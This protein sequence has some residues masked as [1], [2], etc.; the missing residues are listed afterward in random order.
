MHTGPREPCQESA[1]IQTAAL[2]HRKSL[3]DD[4]HVALVE[5][6]GRTRRWLASDAARDQPASIAALL[7]SHLRHAGQ[8]LAVF[9]ESRRVSNDENFR[10]SRHAEVILNTHA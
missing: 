5:I 1:E 8:R 6:P 4:C 3:T 10:M 7:H 9:L 2:Q